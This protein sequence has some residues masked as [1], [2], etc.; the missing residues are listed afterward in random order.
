M[1]LVASGHMDGLTEAAIVIGMW[2][3]TEGD[4]AR[5]IDWGEYQHMLLYIPLSMLCC[6][7]MKG[8]FDWPQY[9]VHVYV[10]ALCVCACV[11]MCKS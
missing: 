9:T 1:W 8:G 7:C 11:H 6:T 2:A 5:A 10:Q 3:G 4:R